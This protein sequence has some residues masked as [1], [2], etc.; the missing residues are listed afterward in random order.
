[1]EVIFIFIGFY[2]TIGIFS[3]F[4]TSFEDFNRDISF[5]NRSDK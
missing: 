5:R 2:W 4:F 1:M 3:L